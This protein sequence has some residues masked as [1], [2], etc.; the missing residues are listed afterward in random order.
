[1]DG[2]NVLTNSR[3]QVRSPSHPRLLRRSVALLHELRLLDRLEAAELRAG[4]LLVTQLLV[5]DRLVVPHYHPLVPHYQLLVRSLVQ[6]SL[7]R[8]RDGPLRDHQPVVRVSQSI[9]RIRRP[10][11][12]RQLVVGRPGRVVRLVGRVPDVLVIRYLVPWRASIIGLEDVRL[13]IVLR[14]LPRLP[15]PPPL[16]LARAGW[17]GRRQNVVGR[18]HARV[19]D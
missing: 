8:V 6:I 16:R 15:V 14:V 11:V 2:L 4:H 13:L 18:L 9:L 7:G 19:R 3:Q 5:P 1:M 17:R 12:P 10:I